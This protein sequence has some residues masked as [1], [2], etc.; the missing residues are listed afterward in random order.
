MMRAVLTALVLSVLAITSPAA[1]EPPR[2]PDD[3]AIAA[4]LAQR[5]DTDKRNVGIVVGVIDAAGPRIVSHGTFGAADTR[6]VDA[7]TVFEIGSISKVFTSLLL[8]DMVERGEVRLDDPVA[9][10]LP[11]TVRVP[12]KDGRVI[13]LQDLSTHTSALPRLPPDF[14]VT[15]PDNPYADYTVAKLYESLGRITLTRP[16]GSEFEYSNLGAGLLG[17][18][19]ALR[20]GG[21]YETLVRSRILAPLKMTDTAIALTTDQRARLARGHN[22]RRDPVGNWD[23]ASVAG[24]GAW[25]STMRD[26][27]RFL[28]AFVTTQPHGLSAAAGR[29]RSV[30]RPALGAMSMRL[31]WQALNRFDTE[32]F[33]HGGMTGGY[34]AFVAFMPARRTGV[35]VL[36]NMLASA[37]G[38]EDIGLH[39]LDPR[40]PLERPA[41]SR[42]RITLPAEALTPLVGRYE[43]RPGFVA[44]VTQE[45][46]RLFVQPSNQPR[47][48]VFAEGPRT[49]FATI[50]D[51]Q[52]V[53]DVDA[54]GR[55]V[56]MTLQQGGGQLTGKRLADDAVVAPP[57]KR[58]RIALPPDALEPYVGRFQLNA[59][60]SIVVTREEGRL[61]AQA[62]GQG[63]F[64]LFAESTDKFFAEVGGIEIAFD[65]DA[66][67]R[68]PSFVI[69][70]GGAAILLKRVE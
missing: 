56:S 63:R 69:R 25:R 14:V 19:L 4:I 43:L 31:G 58:P 10:F 20:A 32:I 52:F 54:S 30:E 67:G 50:V 16:I 61:F 65:R 26:M 1:Q 68:I 17:H 66:G 34:A 3:A 42:T 45:A 12:E 70:Q 49:F 21:D 2:V 57:P 62:T 47:H 38:V 8:A 60:M 7:D 48:E 5:I 22:Q 35:V 15:N 11:P 41:S 18:A 39:L 27:M 37:T 13:T 51:A 23:M 55:A 59:A 28:N 40:M 46:G 33:S 44:T 53:F 24:A 9:K 36:S 29:M 64:E 6:R